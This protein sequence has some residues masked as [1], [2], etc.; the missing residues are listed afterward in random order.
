MKKYYWES[1]MKRLSYGTDSQVRQKCVIYERGNPD[2]IAECW[3]V[4]VAEMVV[5]SMNQFVGKR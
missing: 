5:D 4:T 3:D 1:E 2:R